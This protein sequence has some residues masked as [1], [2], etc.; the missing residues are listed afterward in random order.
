MYFGGN[1]F[2]TN[3]YWIMVWIYGYFWMRTTCYF[4]ISGTFTSQNSYLTTSTGLTI[5]YL[6]P[7]T[8]I[9]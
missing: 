6:G 4:T 3:F 7:G 5:V 8:A 9:F 1:S 2:Y